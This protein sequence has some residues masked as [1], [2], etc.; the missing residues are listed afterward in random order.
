M[1]TTMIMTMAVD[2]VTNDEA[3][4]KVQGLLKVPLLHSDLS[5]ICRRS[6]RKIPKNLFEQ[7]PS[8]YTI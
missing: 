3:D 6:R 1:T 5:E 2:V 8:S 4:K 7:T